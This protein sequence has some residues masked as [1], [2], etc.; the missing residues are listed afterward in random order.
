[1]ISPRPSA[2]PQ[3]RHGVALPA[4]V[5][6]LTLVALFLAGS[7]FVALQEARAASNALGERRSLEAAEYG[8]ASL[9]RDWDRRWNLSVPPGDTLGPW[10][11]ALAGGASAAVRAVRATPT[12]VWVVSEGTAGIPAVDRAARRVVGALLRLDPDGAPVLAALTVR[13]SASV[14]GT[15]SVSGADSIPAGAPDPFC[16][17]MPSPVAG[18]AAPD[19]LRVCDGTCGGAAGLVSGA[20]RLFADAA[21][22]DPLGYVA[23][24]SGA[25]SALAARA[26]IVLP[27]NAVVTP[28]PVASGGVCQRAAPGNWGDPS[29]LT[30]CADWLPVIHALGD[31]TVIG[32]AGQG[33]LIAAGDVRLEGATRF[34]GLIV[35][36]DDVDV[37]GDALVLGAVRAGDARAAAGDHTHV[38]NGGQVR[39]SAC[40]VTRAR[41]G[42]A[43]LR[44]VRQRWWTELF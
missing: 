30:P 32:G 8:A 9:L 14:T 13:D 19:T 10:V 35:A 36:A 40:A 16:G 27:P 1:M 44:R 38:T 22:A 41:L 42:S 4:A 28:G 25:W 6:A 39:Y 26:D 33:I 20:P 21:A 23:V 24:P 37:T 2:S 17:T 18:L 12:T 15:G 29:A 43:L 34:A 7:A 5:A 11:H 31:V 3:T